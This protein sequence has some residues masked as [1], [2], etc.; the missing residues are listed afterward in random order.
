[1]VLSAANP[2]A[3]AVQQ[4]RKQFNSRSIRR[5]RKFDRYSDEFR[6]Y[7][8]FENISQRIY[9][10]Q[11]L[12]PRFIGRKYY[13]VLIG[14]RIVAQKKLERVVA[15]TAIFFQLQRVMDSGG[16]QYRITRQE[17][18]SALRSFEISPAAANQ[19]HLEKGV[20][21][22]FAVQQKRV[23]KTVTAQMDG[24]SVAVC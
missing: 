9:P 5:E 7:D 22:Q 24:K 18:P 2:A 4:S 6:R 15:E 19:I 14:E 23:F 21:V 20:K 8:G 12:F 11:L 17:F 3:E 16:N 1:M 13:P 10:D